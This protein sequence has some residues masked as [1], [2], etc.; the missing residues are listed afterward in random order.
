MPPLPKSRHWTK[1]AKTLGISWVLLIVVRLLSLTYR[2]R[3]ER[4]EA[5]DQARAL[6]ERGSYC[7]ALWHEHLFAC[8]IAHRGGRFAPLASLSS[9]GDIVTFVMNRLGFNTVRGSSSRGGP[10]ARDDLVEI[11]SQGWFTA[12][13]VDGPRGPRRRVKGGVVD[14]ARRSGVAIVP[15]VAIA[16]R[17]WVLHRSWDQ[18]KIPKP[19]AR[20]VIAYGDPIVIPKDTQGLLFGEAKQKVRDGLQRTEEDAT[21]ALTR[22]STP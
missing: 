4:R 6:H 17:M 11:T 3:F 5:T 9:D 20:I 8:I 2:F 18:F 13:T 15:L 16:D 14:V 10:E 7:L 1:R 12:L 21:Q 19:F 22:W